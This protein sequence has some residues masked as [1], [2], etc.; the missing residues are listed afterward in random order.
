MSPDRASIA[1][2]KPRS[3][4][5]STAW[6]T[7]AAARSSSALPAIPDAAV[8]A[9]ACVL[10][11]IDELL[12]CV[13][14]LARDRRGD[15]GVLAA[16]TDADDRQPCPLPEPRRDV[17]LVAC[18]VVLE[19]LVEQ[20]GDLAAWV[21]GAQDLAGDGRRVGASGRR[22]AGPVPRHRRVRPRGGTRLGQRRRCPRCWSWRSRRR[23]R[24]WGSPQLREPP[25][26]A[27]GG[28]GKRC[29]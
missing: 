15:V 25:T 8:L 13:V 9:V 24:R 5:I 21:A 3:V 27:R 12:G 14:V 22:S 4:P 1:D 6:S 26:Q 16:G 19:P 28:A 2:L 11:P 29:A 20:P 18:P 7:T 23:S 10:A 17:A